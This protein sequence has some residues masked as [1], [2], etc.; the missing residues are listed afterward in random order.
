MT[1]SVRCPEAASTAQFAGARIG[2]LAA[3]YASQA[4][5][6]SGRRWC[7][8]HLHK[9]ARGTAV[10]VPER[11]RDPA[12]SAAML[13]YGMDYLKIMLWGLLPFAIS[14]SYS[15]A[16]RDAGETV[17]P[18]R[19]TVI[20]VFVNL[21]FNY[22]LIFGKLGFPALGVKGAALATVLSRLA[23]LAVVAGGAHKNSDRFFFLRGVYRSTRISGKLAK[24]IILKGMPLMVNEFFWSSGMVTLTQMLSTR[25]LM[26][27]GALNIAYTFSNLF[28]VFFFSVGTAVAIVIGQS[29]GGDEELAKAQACADGVCVRFR[30]F[31]DVVCSHAG[32]ILNLQN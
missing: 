22:I 14:Q 17:L 13:R 10:L 29:R 32:W 2:E 4:S 15:S 11:R 1:I 5:G 30:S 8:S 26:V 27:V 9:L 3:D 24:N 12:D 28:G 31:W 18:M 20:A 7:C 6:G 16:L 21:V 23:E 25:G 19:A